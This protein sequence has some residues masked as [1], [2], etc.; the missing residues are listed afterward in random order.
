MDISVYLYA[1]LI[2]MHKIS[3]LISFPISDLN[4][5]FLAEFLNT[6]LLSAKL[7]I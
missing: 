1:Y 4:I 7:N 6:Y 3:L 5:H 2:K